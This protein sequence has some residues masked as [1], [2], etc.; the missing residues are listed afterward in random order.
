MKL[1]MIAYNQAIDGE[2]TDILVD[3]NIAGCTKWKK[4]AGE[5]VGSG[6]HLGTKR[7]PKLNNVLMMAMED[8]P[9]VKVMDGVRE[10]RKQFGPEGV[11]AFL[12][13]CEEVT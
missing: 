11:K 10:L 6:V 5:G 9:A 12:L 13:P 7:W 8:V 1:V 2:V 4:A 3:N